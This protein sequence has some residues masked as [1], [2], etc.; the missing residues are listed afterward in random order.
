MFNGGDSLRFAV[1]ILCLCCIA[2]RVL[3]FVLFNGVRLE[4]LCICVALLF[5]F[6]SALVACDLRCACVGVICCAVGGRFPS[7]WFT[8]GGLDLLLGCFV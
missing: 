7:L 3:C 1:L 2:S 4:C 6:D 8:L 5:V